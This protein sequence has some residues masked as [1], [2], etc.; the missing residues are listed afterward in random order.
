MARVEQ[1]VAVLI[2]DVCGSTPLYG[3][4]GKLKALDLI[5]ECLDNISRVVEAER[6]T[7]LR[8]KG[9]DVLQQRTLG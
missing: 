9:D 1:T 4:S 5:E 7:V 3:S 2:A 8:S 6:G